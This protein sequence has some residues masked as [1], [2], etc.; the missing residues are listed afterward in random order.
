MV[1]QRLTAKTE[2][3][4]PQTTDVIYV[5]DVSDTTDSPEGTS[6][7]MEIGNL[8]SGGATVFTGLTDTP[9]TYVGQA[10]KVVSVNVGETALEFTVAASGAA[11]YVT[12]EDFGGVGDGVT[13]DSAAFQS[14]VNDGKP[15]YITKG[16]TFLVNSQTDVTD[17]TYIFGGGET[18][19]L[20]TDTANLIIKIFG[21]NNTFENF[22]L[23][24]TDIGAQ[25]GMNFI[26][27]ANLSVSLINNIINKVRFYDLGGWAILIQDSVGTVGGT[28]HEGAVTASD[29][30][31]KNCNYGIFLYTRAEYNTFSNCKIQQCTYG[32]RNGGGNNLFTGMSITDCTNTGFWSKAG[33]NDAHSQMVSSHINHCGTNVKTDQTLDFLFSGCS[34]FSGVLSF[35]S[36]G[37]TIFSDC[38]LSVSAITITNSPVRFNDCEFSAVIPTYV[39]TGAKPILRNCYTN[40]EKMS[41]PNTSFKELE[42]F[43]IDDTF[44]IP[45]AH[46]IESIIFENTTANIVT[47]GLN[48]G[49]TA[50]GNDVVSAISLGANEIKEVKDSELLKRVFSSTVL[51]TLHISDVTAWN[52]ASVNMYIK[53]K[54]LN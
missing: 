5:V 40:L 19:V 29:C 49:T 35:S 10:N 1:D 38:Q 48:I 53:L 51:Q 23:K 25:Y 54:S 31:F 36:A 52:S 17:D 28:M 3:I 18:S 21:N 41:A 11:Y 24:G 15:V 32:I 47:G 44:T 42:T 27:A 9:S 46:S 16:K 7:K 37:K 12:L 8:P 22:T 30:I 14:A 4:T 6:K 2:L 39:L 45:L 50:L 13:D 43:T 20:K 26:G 34:I 33:T